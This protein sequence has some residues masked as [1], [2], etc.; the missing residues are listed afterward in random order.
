MRVLKDGDW[1]FGN[2]LNALVEAFK[3]NAVESGCAVSDGGST[4]MTVAVAAGVVEV[5]GV[6]VAVGG[7]NVV[8][9]AAS[10]FKR[11]D[12]I[13]VDNTGV[14]SK[15]DGTVEKKAPDIPS[16]YVLLAIV[17]VPAAATGVTNANIYDCRVMDR[18][19][20]AYESADGDYVIEVDTDGN[21]SGTIKLRVNGT[22]AVVVSNDRKLLIGGQS[23]T[24]SGGWLTQI[25]SSAGIHLHLEQHGANATGAI[26]RVLKQ[27][28]A[29]AT[30]TTRAQSGDKLLD[31]Q[32]VAYASDD[33]TQRNV[34]GIEFIQ[35]GAAAG[36]VPGAIVFKVESAGNSY[37]EIMRVAGNGVVIN[38]SAVSTKIASGAPTLNVNAQNNDNGG[39]GWW[40]GNQLNA[41]A[42]SESGSGPNRSFLVTVRDDFVVR[43]GSGGSAPTLSNGT[44]AFRI[45]AGGSVTIAVLS[46]VL[47]VGKHI[48]TS[49][50]DSDS[51]FTAI[52]LRNIPGG[53]TTGGRHIGIDWDHGQTALSA[54]RS[55]YTAATTTEIRLFASNGTSMFERLR[56]PGNGRI[57]LALDTA[58]AS[59]DFLQNSAVIFYKASDTSFGIA[60]KGSDGTVRTATITVA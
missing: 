48:I 44:E 5:A 8:L 10:A 53:G 14:A 58:A 54:I 39:V 6:R 21:G 12:L 49:N 27:R 30:G 29:V 28:G 24:R 7:N 35:T 15:V 42:G 38:D 43:T 52:S 60:M 2:D 37:A 45:T 32:G 3:G 26:I 19:G 16:G 11:Y 9:A 36:T 23:T 13:V 57:C 46:T 50:N 47:T 41:V 18:A 51:S 31:I 55:V 59:G 1:I 33:A 56:V 20:A 40:L 34:A 4:D 25:A 17:E 22:D